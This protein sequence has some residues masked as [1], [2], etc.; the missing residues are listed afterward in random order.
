M[1]YYVYILES[2]KDQSYYIGYTQGLEKRVY[3]H[4][5]GRGRY[6]SKKAP[7]NLVYWEEYDTKREAIIRERQIKKWKSKKLIEKLIHKTRSGS[8]VG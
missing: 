1:K 4:N 3:D 7:W 5:H 2:E 6:S 8:S